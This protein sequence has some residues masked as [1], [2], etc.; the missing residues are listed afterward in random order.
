MKICVPRRRFLDHLESEAIVPRAIARHLLAGGGHEAFGIDIARGRRIAQRH[1]GEHGLGCLK[2]HR[3]DIAEQV[4]RGHGKAG[5][6][7]QTD[8][9][10]LPV[11]LA[12][13]LDQQSL[14]IRIAE[15]AN[16]QRQQTIA[17]G[18]E[19]GGQLG[20]FQ[21]R[22]F[23]PAAFLEPGAHGIEIDWG[24]P[25]QP[26]DLAVD[27]GQRAIGLARR[28]V[29]LDVRFAAAHRAMR[30]SSRRPSCSA[31]ISPVRRSCAAPMSS[32]LVHSSMKIFLYSSV[33]VQTRSP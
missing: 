33:M 31:I 8:E 17:Q 9:F 19:A 25:R 21:R 27:L 2:Q 1:V 22:H 5:A 13:L 3:V 16:R 4:D 24:Q 18:L 15:A 14:D 28:L 7:A 11:E 26:V 12:L 32:V 10:D 29:E 23:A 6:A 30:A 20:I